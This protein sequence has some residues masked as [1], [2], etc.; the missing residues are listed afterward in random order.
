MVECANNMGCEKNEKIKFLL[1]NGAD[2]NK[3]DSAGWTSLMNVVFNKDCSCRMETARL[4]LEYG[5]DIN[6]QNGMGMTPLMLEIEYFTSIFDASSDDYTRVEYIRW[7][8]KSGADPN[9]KNVCGKTALMVACFFARNQVDLDIIKLLLKNG[10]NIDEQDN[11]ELTALMHASGSFCNSK[12][13]SNIK[14][15]VINLL[16]KYGAN[17]KL[18]DKRDNDALKYANKVNPENKTKIIEILS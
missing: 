10:A 8:L 18:I 12:A 3:K 14:E 9:L 1:K 5:A 13:E 6:A 11:L 7:M 2:P 15:K 4:L 17:T 16:L